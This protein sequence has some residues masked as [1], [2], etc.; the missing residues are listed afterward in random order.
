M[1][2]IPKNMFS[3]K[4]LEVLEAALTTALSI[5][6][7]QKQAWPVTREDVVRTVVA[8][9]RERTRD[10]AELTRKVMCRLRADNDR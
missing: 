10:R 8:V 3:A 1:H 5:V 2:T 7:V 6:R 4:E 9:A